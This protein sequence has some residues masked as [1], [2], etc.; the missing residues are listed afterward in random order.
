[1][2]IRRRGR[3]RGRECIRRLGDWLQGRN[4]V[5]R[6]A[7]AS[8][9]QGRLWAL[10]GVSFQPFGRFELPAAGAKGD[11]V[12]ALSRVLHP[13]QLAVEL[14]NQWH[15]VNYSVDEQVLPRGESSLGE[16]G[17]WTQPCYHLSPVK[18]MLCGGKID[19]PF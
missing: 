6:C 9:L 13:S 14:V 7:G 15:A 17:A 18:R 10:H 16:G 12:P 3:G 2:Q 4:L 5:E 1:M 19:C 8:E 11:L